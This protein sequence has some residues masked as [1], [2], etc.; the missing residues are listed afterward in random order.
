MMLRMNLGR[1]LM[2]VCIALLVAQ[3]AGADT[4]AGADTG[5]DAGAATDA[6]DGADADAE[7]PAE[8]ASDA[9]RVVRIRQVI[10]L[11]KQHITWLRAERDVS[12][13][14]QELDEFIERKRALQRQIE[15]EE[16]LAKSD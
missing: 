8:A 5:T 16:E 4:D 9:K 2:L 12:L 14:K 11:D 15:F 1:L 6:G 13:A 10:T 3:H 7:P